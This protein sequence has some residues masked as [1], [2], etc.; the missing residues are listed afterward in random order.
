MGPYVINFD[1]Y[2]D[3]DSYW[4]ALFCKRNEIVYFV[5]FG[6]EHVPEEIK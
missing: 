2:A 6:V 4:I 1:K 3:V 5:S